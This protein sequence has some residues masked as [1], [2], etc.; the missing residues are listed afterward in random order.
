VHVVCSVVLGLF[1]NVT[2]AFGVLKSF[3]RHFL[4]TGIALGPGA[5][6]SGKSEEKSVVLDL[7]QEILPF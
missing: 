6:T 1:S 2:T 5:H 3:L 4:A 7:Q